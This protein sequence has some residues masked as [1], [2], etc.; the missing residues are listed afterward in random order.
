MT[1]LRAVA[2]GA[3]LLATAGRAA[4]DRLPADA[5]PLHY[6]LVVTPDFGTSTFEG[7]LTI[8]IRVEK[9][10]NRLTLNAVDLDVYWAEVTQP[11]GRLLF[12]AVATD[13]A[14]QTATFTLSARILPGT[15]KLHV[16]YGG[17]LRSDGR[18]FYLA[19]AY[20]RK[21]ALSRM[22][23]TGAR[24][25]F[26]SFDEPGFTASFAISAV[27]ENSLTAI[28]NGKL[29][30]DTP[31]PA[32]GKHTLR[33]GTT[34]RMSSYLVA[35]VVGDFRC[36]EREVD[37]IPLRA[38]TVPEQSGRGRAA[39][40]AL[41][42]AFRAV[43][44]YFTLRYPFRKLDLVAVPGGGEGSAGLTGTLVFD[45]AML[46]DPDTAPEASRVE[47]ALAVT[48][49]VARQWV[50]DVVSVKWWDDLWLAEGLA[51]WA[52]PKALAGPRPPSQLEAL[53]AEA[54]GTA[55]GVDALRSVRP[56]RSPVAADAEIEESFDGWA[57]EKA[58]AVF[59][60]VEEWLGSD[61]FRDALNAFVRSRAYEP[62]AA[63]ELWAQLTAVSGQPVDRVMPTWAIR[64]GVPV[65]AVD[66][67]CDGGESVVSVE[68]RR[69]A[70]DRAGAQPEA[71]AWQIPLRIRGV[72]AEAPMLVFQSRL[73]TEPRQT[74]RLTG[75]FPGAIVNAGAVGYFRTLQTPAA[76][77]RLIP[78]ARDRMTP[79]ERLRFLD[80]TWALAG[81]GA[82][83]FGDYL[84]LVRALA[85]DATPAVLE[86]IAA[87]LTLTGDH[88]SPG[89]AKDRFEAWVAATFEPVAAGL[90]WQVAPGESNDRLRLR[91]ALLDILGGAARD[92]TT[93]ASARA[94]AAAHLA[95]GSV[96]HRSL[97]P[98]VARLAAS[99]GD[100]ALLE[101]L[102]A[103]D[104]FEALAHARDP[105]FVTR[106]LGAALDGP[107]QSDR[108]ATWLSAA[109]QNPAVNVQAWQFLKAR[110]PDLR[111]R[112]A[113]PF[114]VASIVT[115]A[116][117]FCDG[118][119]RD[120]V[121]RFFADSPS[122]PPRTV[123][124]ALDRIDACRDWRLRLQA[125]IQ[126]WVD[127]G[128]NDPRYDDPTTTTR[129]RPDTEGQPT[130]KQRH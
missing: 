113:A 80:D 117:S 110:W 72:G 68:Q 60:M 97:V 20:G 47:A 69:F 14:T 4:A 118:E 28:S 59:R 99:S 93:L 121:G 19:R 29:V 23:A 8:D 89:P 115:A 48:R 63:E 30:S 1:R 25:A 127:R 87:D 26:P 24:R 120:E 91:V 12:P 114:E 2:C 98:V 54:T 38:C 65:L 39:L 104:A 116:G 119:M 96:L 44:R 64:P 5:T 123:R 67:V 41:E 83:G 27:V 128:S 13:P 6:Q 18:G 49:G 122:A 109:F 78:L 33:F 46:P 74:F 108:A 86:A 45:E 70:A 61:V 77:A 129:R 84:A 36:L 56:L 85:A 75:C 53:S 107:G 55:M 92:R 76:L 103:L 42:A 124:L 66:A 81:V 52:A 126:E 58:A 112:L 100:A 101:R 37:G 130:T 125:S 102:P 111:P 62:A 50:G 32:F 21:Y 40:D 71:G 106:T 95:G 15:I 22:V 51:A 105:A 34:P 82:V 11:G 94:L 9:A 10:T 79:A 17:K 73:L 3:L 35:L 7:D 43:S 90:G 57:R 16:R 88:L 31:G